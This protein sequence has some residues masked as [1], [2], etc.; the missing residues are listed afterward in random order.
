MRMCQGVSPHSC[1]MLSMHGMQRA[2]PPGEGDDRQPACM[3]ALRTACQAL[4]PILLCCRT[5]VFMAWISPL[6]WLAP[7]P[8]RCAAQIR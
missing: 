5:C 4:L 7:P 2:A 8:L 6:E 3:S 1:A